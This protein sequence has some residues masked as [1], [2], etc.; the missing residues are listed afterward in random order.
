MTVTC[1]SYLYL[2]ISRSF[3]LSCTKQNKAHRSQP[4]C[5]PPPFYQHRNMLG[6]HL[7]N[8]ASR[9]MWEPYRSTLSVLRLSTVNLC[10]TNKGESPRRTSRSSWSYHLQHGNTSIYRYICKDWLWP[11]NLLHQ[12]FYVL[13]QPQGLITSEQPA[14]KIFSIQTTFGAYY[15]WVTYIPC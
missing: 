9:T 7:D 3:L 12:D 6:C 4:R 5:K 8:P 15:I 11:N 10:S 1:V 2:F 14:S 13:F